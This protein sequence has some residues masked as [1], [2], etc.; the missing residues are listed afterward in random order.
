MIF[1]KKGLNQLGAKK[2]ERIINSVS[3]KIDGLLKSAKHGKILR[4]GL[5]R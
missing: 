5:A 2:I 1:R 4:E 3:N